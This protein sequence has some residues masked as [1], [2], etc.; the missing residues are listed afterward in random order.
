MSTPQ[1][2]LALQLD[3]ASAAIGQDDRA[4]AEKALAEAERLNPQAPEIAQLRQALQ[5]AAAEGRAA[6]RAVSPSC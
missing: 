1:G 5:A 3:R 6:Q 4:A 2:Q